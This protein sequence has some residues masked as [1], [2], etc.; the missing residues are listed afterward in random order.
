MIT[1]SSSLSLKLCSCGGMRKILFCLFVY[2]LSI[3]NIKWRQFCS[4]I[5]LSYWRSHGELDAEP[6]LRYSQL[7]L[8]QTG[9]VII[10]KTVS[11]KWPQV[12][13][14]RGQRLCQAATCHLFMWGGPKLVFSSLSSLENG[15]NLSYLHRSVE[16]LN[17]HSKGNKQSWALQ[18]WVQRLVFQGDLASWWKPKWIC[19]LLGSVAGGKLFS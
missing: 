6:P 19:P 13:K 1:S 3:L 4:L 12:L 5:V 15:V 18:G 7:S 11:M 9:N 8:E 10:S 16:W 2:V 17:L 14:A